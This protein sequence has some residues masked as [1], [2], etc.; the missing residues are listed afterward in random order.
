MSKQSA[1]GANDAWQWIVGGWN[2]FMKRPV[3]WIVLTLIYVVSLFVLNLVPMIGALLAALLTP[4]L[5]G[6]LLHG[7]R[8]LGESRELKPAHLFQAF[9]DQPKL[10]QLALLGVVPLI[11][12]LLQKGL[13]AAPIPQGLTALLGLLLSLAAACALLFGIP[14]VMLGNQQAIDAVQTSLRACLREPVAV[15]VFMGLALL[16][17]IAA[18][19]PLGLGLLVYLP[20]MV[21]A[22]HASY[23]QVI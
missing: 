9:Q 5:V 18:M 20:V 6:G 21:G 13:V 23:R 10:I 22:M 16:L 2:I 17:A 8:E 1:L 4:A 11:V 12:T 19:I 14:L 7:V 3:M 15:G